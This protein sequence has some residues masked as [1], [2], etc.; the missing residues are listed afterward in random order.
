MRF[1]KY[2]DCVYH[3]RSEA[4]ISILLQQ[5]TSY[6]PREGETLHVKSIDFLLEDLLIEWHP[7]WKNSDSSRYK[8]KKRNVIQQLPALKDKNLVFL[9]T[10]KDFYNEI[11]LRYCSPQP[12]WGSF[13]Q[14]WNRALRLPKQVF[15][16]DHIQ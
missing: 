5:Y 9:E 16:K 7:N 4:A 12:S 8:S 13:A 14:S 1:Y 11:I 10:L 15:Y 6:R 3:S 2:Q